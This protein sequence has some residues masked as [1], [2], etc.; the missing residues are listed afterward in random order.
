MDY[1]QAKRAI[2]DN[3]SHIGQA[4]TRATAYAAI[5]PAERKKFCAAN[6]LNDCIVQYRQIGAAIVELALV[7]FTG[8]RGGGYSCGITVFNT[9]DPDLSGCVSIDAIG[10]KLRQ[11]KSA[12]KGEA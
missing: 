5:P 3:A 6:P 8:M 1:I 4:V 9:G 2:V 10:D 11:I 12:G 7:D